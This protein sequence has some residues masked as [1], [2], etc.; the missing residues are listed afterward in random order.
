MIVVSAYHRPSEGDHDVKLFDKGI[1][2]EG[3]WLNIREQKKRPIRTHLRSEP[4]S[5]QSQISRCLSD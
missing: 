1:K 4:K 5:A 3:V 2:G